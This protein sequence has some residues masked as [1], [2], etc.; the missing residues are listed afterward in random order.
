MP[1]HPSQQLQNH[2]LNPSPHL[3]TPTLSHN[4]HAHP[5]HSHTH[6]Q[7]DAADNKKKVTPI[8]LAAY[9]GKTEAMILLLK[10]GAKKDAAMMATLM[11]SAAEGGKVDSIRELLSMGGDVNAKNE[12]GH[13]AL[14][15]AVG[16][17]NLELIEFLIQK[18]ADANVVCGSGNTL[19]HVAAGNFYEKNLN[20]VCVINYQIAVHGHAHMVG[21]LLKL[22]VNLDA[23]NKVGCTPVFVASWDGKIDFVRE[24]IGTFLS[25]FIFFYSF[26]CSSW[27]KSPHC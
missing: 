10:S 7:V 4:F 19:M 2:T 25:F 8:M 15:T 5:F 1:H 23:K 26:I 9:T 11:L 27:S 18:G 13:T 24:A 6:T 22:G 20:F 17:G 21:P 16:S 12:K 3:L 14:Y